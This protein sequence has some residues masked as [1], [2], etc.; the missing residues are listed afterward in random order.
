MGNHGAHWIRDNED[1]FVG[2]VMRKDHH[3]L[4]FNA[5]CILDL[6]DSPKV[7]EITRQAAQEHPLSYVRDLARHLAQK[8]AAAKIE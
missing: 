4:G 2:Y 7:R 5:L 3:M 8:R 6:R 1:L